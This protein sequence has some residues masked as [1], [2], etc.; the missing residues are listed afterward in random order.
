MDQDIVM[1][2]SLM[3]FDKEAVMDYIEELQ[4]ENRRLKK[5]LKE[6]YE[7]VHA[8][9]VRYTVE[10]IRMEA[11]QADQQEED[12]AS[13]AE[14]EPAA[15][16]PAEEPEEAP[17]EEPAEEPVKEPAARKEIEID[18]SPE[19][20]AEPVKEPVRVKVKVRPKR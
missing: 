13:K 18:V 3:G 14:S 11:L 17:A 2:T 9:E 1:K 16:E 6:L 10:D 15:A 12:A 7:Q 4:K 5:E 19:P 20:E 8:D